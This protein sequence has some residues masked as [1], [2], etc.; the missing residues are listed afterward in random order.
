MKCP[1]GREGRRPVTRVGSQPSNRLISNNDENKWKPLPPRPC[2]L[3]TW[4]SC[5]RG[6]RLQSGAS[7]RPDVGPA[8]P[9]VG[10]LTTPTPQAGGDACRLSLDFAFSLPDSCSSFLANLCYW[11]ADQQTNTSA[12]AP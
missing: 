8:K 6:A 4:Q 7:M 5:N 10:Q 2:P 1:G 12:N 9:P 3:R 11:R